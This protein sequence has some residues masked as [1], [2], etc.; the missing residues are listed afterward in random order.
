MKQNILVIV[1][2]GNKSLK[3]LYKEKKKLRYWRSVHFK[4]L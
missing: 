3:G 2:R 1:I 4:N